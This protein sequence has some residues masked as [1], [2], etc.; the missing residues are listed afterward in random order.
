MK[1]KLH[2]WLTAGVLMG[3]AGFLPTSVAH[4]QLSNMDVTTLIEGL[5]AEGMNELLMHLAQT[6]NFQDPILR[7]QL[8]INQHLLAQDRFNT[9]AQQATDAQAAADLRRQGAEEF[10]K[11]LN[12]RRQMIADYPNHEQRPIWQ[13]QLAT[14]LLSDYL[15]GMNQNATQFHEFGVTT[16]RQKQAYE[17]AVIEALVLLEQADVTFFELQTRLAQLPD[18][19]EKRVNTG[20]WDRMM[21]QFYNLRTQYALAQARY[22]VW[23]LPDDSQY[24]KNLDGKFG[25]QRR[26]VAEERARLLSSAHEVLEKLNTG[27]ADANGI[28]DG[29]RAVLARIMAAQGEVDPALTMIDRVIN[30]NQPNLVSLEARL[31]KAYMQA[32]KNN[33]PDAYLTLDQA[34]S[35]TLATSNLL[36]RLLVTDARH[37][38]LLEQADKAPAAQKS[39]AVAAAYAPYISLMEDPALGEMSVSLRNYIQQRWAATVSP[40]TNLAQVPPLVAAAVAQMLRSEGQNMMN[41]AN[42]LI[43]NG[44][45]SRGQELEKQ[46][47]PKLQRAIQ[48]ADTLL[49][50]SDLSPAARSNAMYEKALSIYFTDRQNVAKLIEAAGILVDLAEQH[51]DQ[52]RAADALASAMGGILHPLHDQQI[53]QV[54]PA[55][56]RA[57][58]LMVEKFPDLPVTHQERLYYAARVLIPQDLQEETIRVLEP[59]PA[60]HRDYFPS[61]EQ[62]VRSRLALIRKAEADKRPAMIQEAMAF[63]L[64]A[65]NEATQAV[66]TLQG[67]AATLVEHVAGDLRILRAD[68]LAMAGNTEQAIEVLQNFEQDYTAYQDLI[69]EALGKRILLRSNTGALEEVQREASQM[70]RSFPDD[71]APIIDQVL[72]GM[73]Q[74]IDQLRHQIAHELVPS[75]K[76]AKEKQVADISASAEKLARMLVDWAMAKGFSEDEMLPFQLVLGKS[77]RMA[78]KADEAVTYLQPLYRKYQNELDVLIEMGEALYASGKKDNL[79]QA[80]QIFNTIITGLPP[81][82][83][84]YPAPWW[85]AWMRRMQ[86]MEKLDEQTSDIPLRVRQLEQLDAELGGEPYK[87]ELKRMALKFTR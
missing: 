78:G 3:S 2:R 64:N 38:L 10:D 59:L 86:L 73:D 68:L 51:P 50:R 54:Q 55:Y 15:E 4:A 79:V 6:E 74:Q 28:G 69:R 62:I 33:Y 20:L 40:T 37:R 58:K 67:D 11:A 77:M 24:F 27:R 56:E 70:M 41:E 57:M 29:T 60:T 1:R 22:Y 85:N 53:A 32:K 43:V 61:R 83:N 80:G 63:A 8:L 9:L 31:A 65:Q 30:M 87:S 72:T 52:P 16:T 19:T 71:A 82:N 5:R 25:R 49:A 84:V 81:E 26:T 39:Q 42:A 12:I 21:E 14:Q 36:I 7:Q 34:A 44:E 23:L 75:I 35:H 47:R 66:T 76:T 13:T 45:E 18:H 17:Q 46:A 48:I